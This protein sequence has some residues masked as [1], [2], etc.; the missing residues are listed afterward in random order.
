MSEA[1][2]GVVLAVLYAYLAAGLP[3]AAA[4]VCAGA[5]RIDPQARGAPWG[6]RLA[7][8]PG[9]VVLWP[10]LARRW[11]RIARAMQ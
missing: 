9:A 10:L 3:F 8:F 7:I 4:F 5:P 11:L 2:A 6:F 1:Q